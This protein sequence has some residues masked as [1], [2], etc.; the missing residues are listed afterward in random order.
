MF[1][2]VIGGS[3]SG[4]SEYAENIAVSIASNSLIYIATMYPFDKESFDK[5]NRHKT[6]RKDKGFTTIECF[7]DLLSVKVKKNSTVLIDC[8]SNLV[9]NEMYLGEKGNECVVKEVILGIKNIQKQSQNLIIVSNDIFSD[10]IDYDNETKKYI[11]NIGDINRELGAISDSLVEVVY[12]IPIYH[13][14]GEKLCGM[15]LR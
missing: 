10:G 5:I 1:V 11:K 15:H 3:G 14:G 7:K 8:L 4:K 2:L 6:M 12:S 9:A 13:K